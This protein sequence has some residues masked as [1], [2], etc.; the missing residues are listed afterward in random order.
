MDFEVSQTTQI[1]E[2]ILFSGNDRLNI[3]LSFMIEHQV[4]V[5]YNGYTILALVNTKKK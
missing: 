4:L 5:D 3:S 2:V 1:S